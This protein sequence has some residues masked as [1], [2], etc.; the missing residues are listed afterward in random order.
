M[1]SQP[2]DVFSLEEPVIITGAAGASASPEAVPSKSRPPNKSISVGPDAFIFG[3][4]LPLPAE[5]L[6]PVREKLGAEGP[7]GAGPSGFG[8]EV[9]REDNIDSKLAISS[10]RPDSIERRSPTPLSGG[11]LVI[12]GTSAR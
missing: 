2:E 8:I 5:E 9:G 12:E 7:L 6:D 1:S 10:A 4:N 11:G 3:M